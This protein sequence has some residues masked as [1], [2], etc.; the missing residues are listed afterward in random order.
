MPPMPRLIDEIAGAI[1]Q[2]KPRR[3]WFDRL[4]PGLQSELEEVKAALKAGSL[5]ASARTVSLALAK[6]LEKRSHRVS[7]ETVKKWLLK[8]SQTNS[9]QKS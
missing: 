2:H 1:E 4:P 9:Q 3:N 5:P 6:M 8:N 7:F